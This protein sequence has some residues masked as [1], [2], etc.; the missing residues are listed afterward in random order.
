MDLIYCA[1]SNKRLTQIA[2]DAGYLLGVR[3][4]KLDYGFPISFVDIDYKKPDFTAHLGVVKKHKPKYAIV[5][6][7]SELE[8]SEQD[9]ARAVNQAEQLSSYCEI[10]LIVPKL[11]SQIPLIPAKWAIA[12]SIPTSYGG[13]K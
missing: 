13:A 5:P 3:S 8:T 7:L 1:G 11:S 10:P 12:Y 6:D 2:Q 4:D 9:I